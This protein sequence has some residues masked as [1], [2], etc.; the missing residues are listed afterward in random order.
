ML[1]QRLATVFVT[2]NV[3]TPGC[4][5][6]IPSGMASSLT[7]GWNCVPDEEHPPRL[8]VLWAINNNHTSGGIRRETFE[9]AS[10]GRSVMK[11]ST[12][13]PLPTCG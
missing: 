8:M 1:L 2:P 3:I 6:G 5:S 13:T 9:R 11:S 7:Y 4:S 12:W 10:S